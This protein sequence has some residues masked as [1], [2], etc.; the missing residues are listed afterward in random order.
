LIDEKYK[1]FQSF[2]PDSTTEGMLLM[3]AIAVLTS[4][5]KDDIREGGYGGMNHPDIVMENIWSLANRIFYEK[6]YSNWLK[7][8][9]RDK[10]INQIF[11]LD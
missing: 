9:L 3:A 11:D 8:D 5:N 4:M 7:S 2:D 1:H 10:K 6:E